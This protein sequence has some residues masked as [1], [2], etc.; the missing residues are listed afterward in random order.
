MYLSFT[1]GPTLRFIESRYGAPMARVLYC[2]VDPDAVPARVAAVPLGP[3][4]SRDVQRRPPAGARTPDA[5]ARAAVAAR[6]ASRWSA[7]CIPEDIAWPENVDREIHL[8]PREHP[9]VLRGAALHAERHA[10]RDEAGRAIRRA[11][12]CSRPAPARA[13]V[14]SDW[15]EGLDGI[16]AIGREVLVASEPDETLRYLRDVPRCGAARD[17]AR[18]ARACSRASTRRNSAP[19]SSRAT[20]KKPMTTF[21]LIRHGETDAVGKSI[22]GWRPGWHLN[23][24]RSETGGDVWR[25]GWRA[26][27]IRAIYTSPLE[28]AV[29]TAEAVGEA[30]RDRAAAR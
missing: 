1:G 15:W 26:L 8:S 17:G 13:P 30:A 4:L 12:G 18:R 21:L 16:F 27:P 3:R 2:S 29:E 19:S 9:G 7:R 22:M 28:R 10:R 11:C 23:A 6:A 20:G 5:G 25:R 24:E 14:I